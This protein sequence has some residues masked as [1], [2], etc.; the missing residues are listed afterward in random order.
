MSETIHA[1]LRAQL[2]AERER[3]NGQLAELGVE[4]DSFDEGFADSGQVTAERG[5]VEALVGTLRDTLTDI[6]AALAKFDAGSYGICESC[7]GQ[8]SEARLEAMPA[9]RLC[10]T[11]ASRRR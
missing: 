10:I 11:C 1:A 2:A 4:R 7:G 9:A 3:V 6:D 8:I 5:E